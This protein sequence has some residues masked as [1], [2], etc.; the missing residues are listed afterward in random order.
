MVLKIINALF[1]K[2]QLFIRKN[3]EVSYLTLPS[4]VQFLL[5]LL[6]IGICT[7]AAFSSYQYIEL[8]KTIVNKDAE[9]SQQQQALRDLEASYQQKHAVLNKQ[10]KE[11]EQKSALMNN[12]LESLPEAAEIKEIN[13]NEKQPD[14]ALEKAA[15]PEDAKQKPDETD[16]SSL[17]EVIESANN[18]LDQQFELLN[19]VVKNRTSQLQSA[20]NKAGLDL[21]YFLKQAAQENAQGGPFHDAIDSPFA[22]SKTT[23]IDEMITLNQLTSQAEHW[24]LSLPATDFYVS[25]NYGYRKDPITKR[26]AMHKGIDMAGW[27]K[28]KIYAPSRGKVTRAGRNGGY[29]NFIEL[30]HD[31]GFVTRYGHLAKIKVKRGEMIEKDEV[32][33]LMGSSGRSTSTHLHYEV[34]H[35]GKHINPLKLTRAFENVL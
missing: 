32:I 6:G 20:L 22:K 26:R 21:P 30:Q 24:P 16:N 33:G 10:L 31:N 19:L 9:L 4:F 35:N 1:P 23:L 28:T 29:G 34:L 13:N 3:G 17:D 7:V 12:M 27:H 25:S 15:Q 18:Q 14:S 2:R 5:A 11:I 8:N